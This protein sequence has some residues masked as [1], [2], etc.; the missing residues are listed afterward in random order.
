MEK[1]LS[2]EADDGWSRR[3]SLAAADQKGSSSALFFHQPTGSTSGAIPSAFTRYSGGSF[4]RSLVTAALLRKEIAAMASMS[5]ATGRKL[6]FD[7]G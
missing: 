6:M 2:D 5:F 3:E 7:V 1:T 4:L